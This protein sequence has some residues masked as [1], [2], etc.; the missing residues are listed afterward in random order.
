MMLTIDEKTLNQMEAQHPG[1]R[2]TIV[3]FEE[4]TVPACT[5]CGS[6]DTAT[7][8]CGIV[9]RTIYIAAA[10]TKFKLI[11][12]GPAPGKYFCNTC[13]GFFG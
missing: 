11:P 7:V 13:S 8:G 12:N 9:G 5:R 2:E 10:T 1:I 6:S 4:A 3:Y